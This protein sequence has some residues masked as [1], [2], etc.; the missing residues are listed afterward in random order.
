MARMDAVAVDETTGNI[1]SN[2]L[3]TIDTNGGHVYHFPGDVVFTGKTFFPNG[4]NIGFDEAYAKNYE[5]IEGYEI[6][7]G[8]GYLGGGNT[9]M[10][11]FSNTSCLG[12]CLDLS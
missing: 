5:P 3:V 1:A 4:F 9:R 8:T 12:R 10:Q 7:P 2:S 11:C 6:D